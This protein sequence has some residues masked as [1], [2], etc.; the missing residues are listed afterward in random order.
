MK[1]KFLRNPLKKLGRGFIVSGL[2]LLLILLGFSLIFLVLGHRNVSERMTQLQSA[3]ASQFF[4]TALAL[5]PGQTFR[6][7]EIRTMLDE[8]GFQ[9]KKSTEDLLPR[10]YVWE[11]GAGQ[12]ALTLFRPSFEG[13]APPLERVKAR[14]EF[15]EAEGVLTL[16]T[17]TNVDTAA[18]I[19]SLEAVPK[20]IG[21]YYAGRVRTQS[22][23][24]LSD[25]PVSIRHAVMAIEDVHFLEH[26][27]VS[28]RAILRALLRDIQERRFAE[29]GSTLTQQLMKNLFFS[30]EKA[31]SRKIKEAIYALLTEFSY[32]KEQILEAYLNEVYMGQWSTHEIHGVSEGARYYFNRPITEVSLAQSATLAAIIQAPNAL[33]PRKGQEATLK[34]RNLVLKKMLDAG[35]ILPGEYEMALDEKLQVAG[36]DKNLEDV[37]YFMDLVLDRLPDSVKSRLDTDALSIYTTL[38]PYL[39]AVSSRLLKENLN[40]LI[41]Q[42]KSI[43]KKQEK[44]IHLQSALIVVDVP[45]CAVISLQGG[46]SYRQTQFNRVLQG[47]RQPGSLFKPFVFLAALFNDSPNAPINPVTALD[48]T[49]FE[50][51]YEGQSWKPKNY[52]KEYEPMVAAYKAL[53]N[54]INVPTAR[55]AQMVGIPAIADVLRKAGIS[56]SLPAVPS[57]SLGSADVNPFEVAEAYTTLANLGKYCQLRPVSRVFDENNNLV[58]NNSPQFEERLPAAATFQTVHML[59]GTLTRG[60]AR[61]AASSGIKVDTFAGKTGTTNEN[62]DAWFVGFSPSLLALAWVGYDEEE[63]IGLT[64]AAAALPLWIN[65]IRQAGSFVGTADF[66]PPQG[67]VPYDIDPKSLDLSTNK[68][69]ER[70]TEYF[71]PGTQPGTYCRIH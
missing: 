45:N 70:I 46:R 8:Q 57:L 10:E 68:C 62:K 40:A 1:K 17:L 33:D 5:K 6:V 28:V 25:I 53:E 31:L 12:R 24:V 47:R 23:V 26:K 27:G 4:A 38:N 66:S 69:P 50:W 35:F 34:R 41:N 61:W 7:S 13:A 48:G 60:T 18:S 20:K 36:A 56:S 3:R 65:F 54:S 64:G 32:S 55:L 11:K 14:L 67:L 59:K 19:E 58:L 39:Q 30:R 71:A 43:K 22:P 29:G 42:H 63:K 37:G 51:K 15:E 16:K 44:G 49:P 9:E 21:A 2:L 52:E